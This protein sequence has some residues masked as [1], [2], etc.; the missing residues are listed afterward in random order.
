MNQI[1]AKF[2]CHVVRKFEANQYAKASERVSLHPVYD[3]NPESENHKWSEATPSGEIEMSITNPA[4]LGVFA[5]GKEY[6]VDFTPADQFT[7][8]NSEKDKI[9]G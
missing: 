8:G 1:R 2:R 3:S 4:A 5:E 6:I 9:L 7:S